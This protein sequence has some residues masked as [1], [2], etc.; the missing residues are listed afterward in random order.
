MV[1]SK[2][3]Q[4]NEEAPFGVC[5]NTWLRE[6][7]EA[8]FVLE[9]IETKKVTSPRARSR[10]VLQAKLLDLEIKALPK[11]ANV[12]VLITDTPKGEQNRK[13]IKNQL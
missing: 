12:Y 1:C 5:L 3:R 9:N 7:Q 11:D 4:R 13:P 6:A 10:S 2:N 8:A